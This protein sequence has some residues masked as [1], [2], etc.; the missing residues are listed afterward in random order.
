MTFKKNPPNSTAA[1]VSRRAFIAGSTAGL[2]LWAVGCSSRRSPTPMASASG[3]SAGLGRSRQMP[4]VSSPGQ[5]NGSKAARL[6]E[7]LNDYET[8]HPTQAA[9]TPPHVS[10]TSTPPA[11]SAHTIRAVARTQWAKGNP[12][13][14]RLNP[15]KGI[16][17]VTIHHE[18][19][20]TF[21]S[22]DAATTA[23]RLELIR[24]SHLERLGAGDIGYHFIVDRAG[25][26]WAG[27]SLAYQGAHVKNY[28]EHNVGIMVLG[29]FDKQRPND[30]QLRA[31]Q[32]TVAQLATAYRISSREVRSH[33]EFNPTQCPGRYLQSQMN[34]LRRS[35]G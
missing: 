10:P 3:A 28:N 4:E 20:K 14:Q 16:S 1:E 22:T 25:R 11:S 9:M 34:G 13:G 27:R 2:A 32:I 6:R 19:W 31:L 35:L 17:R 18:G 23:A 7:L 24:Q 5:A 12:I 15:M 26:L 33:Q 21:W 8:R 29:N 30:A